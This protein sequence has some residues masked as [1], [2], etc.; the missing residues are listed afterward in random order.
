MSTMS[1]KGNF[2]DQMSVGHAL[3]RNLSP[4]T[5]LAIGITFWILSSKPENS[6]KC[7]SQLY[8]CPQNIQNYYSVDFLNICRNRTTVN[9]H[10]NNA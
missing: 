10:Q 7:Y 5:Q 4:P 1:S 9:L 6:I 2:S 3:P 8:G